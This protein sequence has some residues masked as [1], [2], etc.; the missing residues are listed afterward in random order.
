[1]LLWP[2]GSGRGL[3]AQELA[4]PEGVVPA[5][6]GDERELAP[7]LRQVQTRLEE[8]ERR[9]REL[10]ERERSLGELS[11]E[12]TRALDALEALRG[13]VDQRI[14][15]LEALRGDGVGRLAKVYAAM[16]PARAAALLERLEPEVA[17]VLVG[18]MK[19][20]RSAAVLASMS[21]ESALRV[22]RATALPLPAVGDA[23]ASE[24]GA[25]DPDPVRAPRLVR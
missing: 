16:P 11:A 8:L 12:A 20:K 23:P 19:G 14:A 2:V 7:L 25:G 18:R 3:A 21:P 24:G 17:T 6:L 4:T 10:A 5:A 1:M 15:T 22:S 9:E 13:T